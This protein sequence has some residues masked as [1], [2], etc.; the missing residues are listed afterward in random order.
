[1]ITPLTIFE[2]RDRYSKYNSP[3]TKEIIKAITLSA[4]PKGG[5]QFL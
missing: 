2:K 4:L 3:K 5:F 1:M